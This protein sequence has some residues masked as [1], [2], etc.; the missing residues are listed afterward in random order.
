M[1]SKNKKTRA[2]M[3]ILLVI[4][5]VGC[6]QLSK[7]IVRREVSYSD[8]I[9]VVKDFLTIIKV[10]NTG[11]FL[12]VGSA[13]PEYVKFIFLTVLPVFVICYALFLV[14]TKTRTPNLIVVGACFLIGGGIGNL[15]DRMRFGSVTDFFHLDFVLFQT[16]IFNMADVSIVLGI[17]LI[18]FQG[19]VLN[20]LRGVPRRSS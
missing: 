14:I 7:L 13:L 18:L 8:R 11:A 4:C 20:A 6:D 15:F 12:S 1:I 5:N 19:Y 17:S 16:G 2:L 3:I 10:E 9:S